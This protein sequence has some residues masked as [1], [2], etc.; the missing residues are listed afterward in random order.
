ML[1]KLLESRAHQA[2]YT[3]FMVA[4]ATVHILLI[5]AATSA[6]VITAKAKQESLDP[7]VLHWVPMPKPA[8]APRVALPNEIA[9]LASALPRRSFNVPVEI[10]TSL[11]SIDLTPVAVDPS[12]FTRGPSGAPVTNDRSTNAS[13]VGD[14]RRAYDASEVETAVTSLG[15]TIPDYPPALRANGLEGKVTAEFV[16]TE[17]GRA[18]VASLRIISASNDAFVE[19]IRRALPRMRFSPAIIGNRVVAQLVQQQFVFR[20]DR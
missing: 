18:D 9:R 2:R 14:G 16:V 12:E 17:L 15:N 11:P 20:L 19:S 6:T 5:Y 8:N 3:H 13:P 1:T 7:V 10:P 4:S